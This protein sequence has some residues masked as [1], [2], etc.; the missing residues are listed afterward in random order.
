MKKQ[1]FVCNVVYKLYS[2]AVCEFRNENIIIWVPIK[3]TFL[4][5]MKPL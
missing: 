1:K 5:L 3:P 4:L 2:F